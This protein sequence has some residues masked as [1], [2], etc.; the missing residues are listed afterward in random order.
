MSLEGEVVPIDGALAL[1]SSH[2]VCRFGLVPEQRRTAPHLH[3]TEV[4][5]LHDYYLLSLDVVASIA[6]PIQPP[7]ITL[8]ASPLDSP[9]TDQYD[10][11]FDPIYDQF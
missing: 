3:K 2:P 5:L 11:H 9:S 4:V 1:G 7:R 6:V 10:G 8:R